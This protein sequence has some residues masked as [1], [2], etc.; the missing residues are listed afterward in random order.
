MGKVSQGVKKQQNY[1]IINMEAPTDL[2]AHIFSEIIGVFVGQNFK[3]GISSKIKNYDIK[4]S[5]CT[6]RRNPP[7][8]R[9]RL[10]SGQKGRS[11]YRGIFEGKSKI[12][13]LRLTKINFS[14]FSS[15]PSKLGQIY[16]EYKY[17]IS[18]CYY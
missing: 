1:Y 3:M 9:R 14:L 11:Y 15:R 17:K 12:L 5:L 7:I 6:V 18:L 4:I 8:W 10:T 2:C 13:S 16:V